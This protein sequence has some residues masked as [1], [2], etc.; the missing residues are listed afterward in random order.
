MTSS[1]K[2]SL[3]I[4]SADYLFTTC[5]THLLVSGLNLETLMLQCFGMKC[6]RPSFQTWNVS[7]LQSFWFHGTLTVIQRGWWGNIPCLFRLLEFQP[8]IIISSI[9]NIYS[10]W[11]FFSVFIMSASSLYWGNFLRTNSRTRLVQIQSISKT[12]RAFSQ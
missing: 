1:R 3:R 4:I 5:M 6:N 8:N 12:R 7:T 9:A 10:L 2:H 11:M